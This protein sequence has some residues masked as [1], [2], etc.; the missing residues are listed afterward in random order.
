[1]GT[2]F[3]HR[4]ALFA[5]TWLDWFLPVWAEACLLDTTLPPIHTL[6]SGVADYTGGSSV[7]FERP[8]EHL[9]TR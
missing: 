2:R 4:R 1:M 5:V 7:A 3:V 8:S 6:V 9:I